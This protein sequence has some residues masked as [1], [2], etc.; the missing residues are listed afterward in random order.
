MLP[1]ES[2][3][4][5]VKR[6]LKAF[7][8]SCPLNSSGALFPP[9]LG[10]PA[11]SPTNSLS[12]TAA[13]L[14]LDNAQCPGRGKEEREILQNDKMTVPGLLQKNDFTDFGHFD[15]CYTRLMSQ[16]PIIICS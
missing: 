15:E 6:N 1:R 3:S 8:Y 10:N 16:Q 12:P 4:V 2:R 5:H 7:G 13:C 9:L 11:Q 14:V